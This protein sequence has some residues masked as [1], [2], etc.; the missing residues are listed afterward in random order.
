MQEILT[1]DFIEQRVLEIPL[2]N[3]QIYDLMDTHKK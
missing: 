2:N 3:T 1:V